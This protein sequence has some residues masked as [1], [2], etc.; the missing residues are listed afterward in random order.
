MQQKIIESSSPS[1]L[2]AKIKKYIEEGWEPIGSH[3][4]TQ[5]RAQLRYSGKQHMDTIHAA[6]YAQTIRKDV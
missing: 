2:N 5:I 6:E 4:A 1:G 3:T